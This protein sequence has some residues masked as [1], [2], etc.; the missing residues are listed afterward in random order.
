[1]KLKKGLWG[2]LLSLSLLVVGLFGWPLTSSAA[3]Q[4]AANFVV[5]P[6]LPKNQ[7]NTKDGYFNLKVTPGS[8]QVLQ[9]SVTNPGTSSRQIDVSPVN[10]TT[11][12]TG[13][14]VYIPSDR[15]DPSA[16][17]TFTKMTSKPISLTLGAHQGKTVTFETK[18]PK[19]G[20]TGEI[21]GGLFVTNPKTSEAS[22]K[23][24]AQ[25]F[26]LANRY[27]VT[28]AVALWCQP[29]KPISAKV[30]LASTKV[31]YSKTDTAPM[32]VAKL[33]NLA[34]IAFGDLQMRAQIFEQANGHQVV[35]QTLKNRSMAPNSW[36]D[37]AIGLGDKP[38]PAGRYTL[39]LKL[40][41][42]DRHWNFTR[43]FTLSKAHAQEQNTSTKP[44]NSHQQ[45][46][47]WLAGGSVLVLLII[48]G[49]YWLGRKHK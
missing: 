2:L 48:G 27:A 29:N 26:Q 39:K 18:I 16:Q 12:D 15:T 5:T 42:G 11:A 6:L 44:A 7:L 32:V 41:S 47:F 3:T 33:R 9:L 40:A 37:S 1:M 10:A 43:P 31:S 21:L 34:P 8:T 13:T 14:I 28:T 49:A 17:T 22:S 19:S 45:V 35:S 36:F 30:Q 38:L 20:F 23:R 24:N 4:P 46:W 25:N